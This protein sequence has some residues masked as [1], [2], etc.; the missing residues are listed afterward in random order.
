MIQQPGFPIFYLSRAAR[1][2]SLGMALVLGVSLLGGCYLSPGDPT[3][4]LPCGPGELVAPTNLAP[5][6]ELIVTSLSPSLNTLTW[7]YPGDCAPT[8]FRVQVF[9]PSEVYPMLGY[10]AELER[11][12]RL[13]A[14]LEEMEV[15][16]QA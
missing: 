12:Q 1:L 2:S 11:M 5:G 9:S 7:D 13:E 3:P 10:Y 8:A 4:L 15:E 6:L 16:E 14:E